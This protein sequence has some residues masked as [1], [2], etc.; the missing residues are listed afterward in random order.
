M[1]F[2]S[3]ATCLWL[4]WF[5]YIPVSFFARGLPFPG[6]AWAPILTAPYSCLRFHI[7][8]SFCYLE[9][10][11]GGIDPSWLT[12][13]MDILGLLSPTLCLPNSARCRVRCHTYCFLGFLLFTMA[14]SLESKILCYLGFTYSL[15]F[16]HTT[17]YMLMD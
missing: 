9:V 6:S 4:P 17:H 8:Y 15:S 11:N 3:S 16:P 12:L 14:I 2:K 1:S 5:P 7:L 13:S 10:L